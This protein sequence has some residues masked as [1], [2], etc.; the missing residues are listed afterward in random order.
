VKPAVAQNQNNQQSEPG[1]HRMEVFNGPRMNVRYYPIN[2]SPSEA[3]TLR[4][5]E[6]AENESI[7]MTDLMELKGQYAVGERLM[8][9]R[10]RMVQER[11]Y[12]RSITRTS[13]GF[14][15]SF[16]GINN[17]GIVGPAGLGFPILGLGFTAAGGSENSVTLSLADGV[18]DEGAIKPA[19]AETMAEQATLDYALSVNKALDRAVVQAS[20]SPRVRAALGYPD[21]TKI[22]PAEFENGDAGVVVT[23]KDGEKIVG[24]KLEENKEWTTVTTK[25]GRKIRVRP[26]EVQR[27][28]EGGK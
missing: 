27:I 18:G 11:L 6:L 1:V 14:A 28:E 21:P 17:L 24:T 22:K 15:G 5:L 3:S 2:L 20:Y 13:Y 8:E 4:D 16:L 19:L 7:Y 25:S 9:V 23:L 12:G 10:R 26:S